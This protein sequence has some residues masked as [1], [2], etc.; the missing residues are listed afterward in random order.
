MDKR[1]LTPVA[2]LIV[3]SSLV[4]I[5]L[6]SLRAS[7]DAALPV[8]GSVHVIRVAPSVRSMER[9]RSPASSVIQHV[10][11]ILQENRSFNDMFMGYK[12]AKTQ[13]FGLNTSGQKVMLTGMPLAANCDIDHSV[14]A[15]FAAYD[16][17]K[18]DGWDSESQNCATN[19]PYRYVNRSDVQIYWNMAKQYVLAD[20]TFASH[21]DGSFIAHQYA[22]AAYANHEVNFPSNSWGCEGGPNDVVPTLTQSRTVGSNV[23]VCE[24]YQ[25]LGDL[26]DAA[27]VSWR[28]YTP[29]L[30][31]WNLWSSYSAINHI[32]QNGNGPDWQNDVI[33]PETQVRTDVGNGKLASMT[34]VVPS[35]QNSDHAGSGSSSGPAWVA[36]VVD[37]IGNSQFWNSTVIFVLWDEWGGWYDPVLPVYEDYDGLGYRIPMIVISPYARVHKVAHKQYEM[38]SVLRFAEDLFGTGQ[39]AAADARAA[40]PANDPQI[41]N[42][43]QSPRPFKSF[44]FGRLPADQLGP[45]KPPHFNPEYGD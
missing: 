31:S 12:G 16:N 43:S 35:W 14:Y 19:Y 41:F 3:A 32:Y 21:L 37:A 10:V 42:F 8:A 7:A 24:D 13:K 17:G 45:I 34:W 6:A 30:Q 20:H 44:A 2:Q 9:S 5:G 38:A 4:L 27:S 33:S 39:L 36:S 25:T 22:I 11:F 1:R 15:F 40:D 23:P 18:N 29:S 26:L 28:F